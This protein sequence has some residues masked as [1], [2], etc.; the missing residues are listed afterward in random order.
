MNKRPLSLTIISILFIATGAI[1][2]GFELRDFQTQRLGIYLVDLI[3]IICGVYMFRGHDWARWLALAWMAFHVVVSL[4]H[5]L[6]EVVVHSLLLGVLAYFLF[7][8]RTNQ[9]FRNST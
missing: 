1:S 6:F 8:R 9:F 2:L 4:F 7:R 5:S 3:A